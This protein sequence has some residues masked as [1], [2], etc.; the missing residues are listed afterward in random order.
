M[1]R[2]E[3]RAFAEEELLYGT[4]HRDSVR[5]RL[6]A[7]GQGKST[8]LIVHRTG[9][10]GHGGGRSNELLVFIDST[11]GP[12]AG[13]CPASARGHEPLTGGLGPPSG[14]T[15][16]VSPS[17][18]LAAVILASSA[19][20]GFVARL[21][22]LVSRNKAGKVALNPANGAL[23]LP[24]TPVGD[25]DADLLAAVTTAGRLLVFPVSELPELARGKGNLFL[26]IPNAAFEWGEA[27][28]LGVAALG[29]GA[30]LLI[31]AGQRYLRLKGSDLDS[32]RGARAQRGAKLPRG[33]QRVD[34]IEVA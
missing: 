17:A 34:R 23:V 22:D 11:V 18:A 20:L 30:E 33:F 25:P 28:L 26:N 31:H 9:D 21:E 14:A 29:G 19:G 24:P 13:A 8:R 15:A 10:A 32:Y 5:E 16:L 2:D 3:A 4:D 27:A 6:G 7:C 1:P 12:A